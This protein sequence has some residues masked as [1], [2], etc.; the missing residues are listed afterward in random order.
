MEIYEQAKQVFQEI[1]EKA[2]EM[3]LLVAHITPSTH[4]LRLVFPVPQGM[5]IIQAQ[6]YYV[7]ALK[8][9]NVDAC[10][11]DLARLSFC[12]PEDYFLY[13]DEDELFKDRRSP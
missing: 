3:G 7:K 10:T 2:I 5:D 4:G 9:T 1:K 13:I 11:K 8:L 12:V 6:A